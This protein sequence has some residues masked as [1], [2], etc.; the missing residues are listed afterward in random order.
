M[1]DRLC[2]NCGQ[3]LGPDLKFCGNC[4]SPLSQTATTEATVEADTPAPPPPEE[5]RRRGVGHTI[6]GA[7]LLVCGIICVVLI[8]LSLL[9]AA[10]GE[11]ILSMSFGV[12]FLGV[13]AAAT[14]YGAWKNLRRTP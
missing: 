12:V 1:A 11:A 5:R 8:A 13:L 10:L 14:L 3:E 6:V 4:G 9:L 2:A 7:A